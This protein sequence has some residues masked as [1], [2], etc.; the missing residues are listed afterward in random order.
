MMIH[1][2]GVMQI[3]SRRGC[4]NRVLDLT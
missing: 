4:E 1:G 3:C 2:G